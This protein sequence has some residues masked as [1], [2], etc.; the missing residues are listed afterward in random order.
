MD[1]RALLVGSGLGST[2]VINGHVRGHLRRR[3][4]RTGI[5]EILRAMTAVDVRISDPRS[6]S[7]DG[8]ASTK[9]ARGEG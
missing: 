8:H 7:A 9:P 2:L 1:W 5:R 4:V 3:T 6:P